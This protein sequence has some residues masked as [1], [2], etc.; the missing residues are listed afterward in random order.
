MLRRLSRVHRWHS[1]VTPRSEYSAVQVLA[2]SGAVTPQPVQVIRHTPVP[3]AG[4]RSRCGG[5]SL[6]SPS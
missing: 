6:V 4:A 3:T 5:L 1:H 2:S